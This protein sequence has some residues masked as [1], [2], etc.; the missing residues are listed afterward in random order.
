MTVTDPQTPAAGEAPPDRGARPPAPVHRALSPS[1]A[2]DF[3]HCP[4]LYRFRVIDRLPEAPSRGRRRG[5]LVHAVL[6]RLF[7]LPAADRTWA[8]ARAMLRP[9]GSG[10]WA[11]PGAGRAVR[12]GGRRRR[13]RAAGSTA[14][15]SCVDRWFTLEDPTRPR[16]GRA[17][18]VRR[19]GAGRRAAAARLRRPAR[20]RTRP[21]TLRVVDY[22]T[23]E[24]PR[25]EF[26]AKA[27]F[28]MRFY[29]LVLWRPAGRVPRLLQLVYLGRRRD[30]CATSP[31]RPTCSPPSAS[32][33]RCG[34]A[35]ERASEPATGGPA[36]PAVRLVRPPGVLP[37]V[38]RHPAA[39][40]GR[41]VP[42]ARAAPRPASAR[43]H[44][45]ESEAVCQGLRVVPWSQGAPAPPR[46]SPMPSARHLARSLSP[47]GQGG[48]RLP[49]PP[50]A[51]D[52]PEQQAARG[53][54][55]RAPARRERATPS[56][57]PAP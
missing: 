19:D 16:A 29:A 35:I 5:T 39:A 11:E 27:L 54:D 31:T 3:M 30:R 52:G 53:H 26:E 12:R 43:G 57:A 32:C 8:R 37:G 49:S 4:L 9:S 28:Q 42:G 36:R 20:R 45:P 13:A 33:W 56:P 10:C 50:T 51:T 22:K 47:A 17:R 6:E 34:Q 7:D 25:P 23:G 41:R 48:R 40:A 55:M 38:R 44:R 18:A 46:W 1:R 14:P 24:A 15:A 21:A 2:A